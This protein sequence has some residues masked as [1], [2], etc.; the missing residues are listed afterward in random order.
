MVAKWFIYNGKSTERDFIFFI[1]YDGLF[2]VVCGTFFLM[3]MMMAHTRNEIRNR[4]LMHRPK[5]NYDE[6]TEDHDYFIC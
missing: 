4:V 3:L 1:V 5:K 6:V 2:L